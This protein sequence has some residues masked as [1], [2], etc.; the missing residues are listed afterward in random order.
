MTVGCCFFGR[1][2]CELLVFAGLGNCGVENEKFR[3][4]EEFFFVNF[5]NFPT[6]NLYARN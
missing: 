3:S 5:Q 1:N 2:E 4:L 6:K